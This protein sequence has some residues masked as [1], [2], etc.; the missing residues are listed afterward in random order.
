M[1]RK[2]LTFY[3]SSLIFTTFLFLTFFILAHS[4]TSSYIIYKSDQKVKIDI[5][6]SNRIVHKIEEREVI[7]P[8]DQSANPSEYETCYYEL[9][10][11][12]FLKIV[13]PYNNASFPKNIA[14]PEFCWE[15]RVDNIW[16]IKIFLPQHPS[17]LF[18][19]TDKK[20]WSPSFETWEKIKNSSLGKYIT[21]EVRGC[22]MKNGK[23]QDEI[24]YKDEV[25]FKISEYPA[26]NIIV[27]RL[28]SP[29]FHTQKT[30]D[31][32][33]RYI[34]SFETKPFLRSKD[35]YCTNCHAFPTHDGLQ[36]KEAKLA[37][38]VRDQLP[39]R[40]FSGRG[41][42]ILGIYNFPSQKG[43]TFNINSFFM[44]WSP[45]GRKIAVTSGE[46]V[47]IRPC[48]TLE[49]QQFFVLKSDITIVDVETNQITPL[50]GASE[51]EYMENFPTW[52]P[53]GRTIIFSRTEEPK[54]DDYL[55][56]LKFNLYKIEY[57]NGQGG[58]PIP[59]EGAAFNG[60]SNYAARYSPN[61][62]WVVFNQAN[63]ASLVEPT[64]QLWIL[65]TQAG[66]QPRKLECNVDY[67]MNSWHSWSSNSRWLLFASK[68]DDGIFARIYLTEIDE[69]G[70]ASPPVRLPL[71]DEPMMCFN[72]PEFLNYDQEMV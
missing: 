18:I 52:S 11:F 4:E 27:Y 69:N 23:R 57:N 2:L 72:V 36:P 41:K 56:R 35:I 61:G 47:I 65:S 44:G 48:I 66:S 68:R 59:I 50:K 54:S 33:Y 20:C 45:D 13:R 5:F 38:A 42:R 63:S 8:F 14:P 70:H 32:Y 40:K 7:K 31:I 51:P 3:L 55:L 15:D 30:P 58:I 62:R 60:K 6:D 22:V 53:D 64:S 25:K 12:K 16:L 26:D 1:K 28:V 39:S 17:P 37:I 10:E 46:E 9:K 21:L 29:L 67:A 49:T 34:D 43:K 71:K 24:I 19:I